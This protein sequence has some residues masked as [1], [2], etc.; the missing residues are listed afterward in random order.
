LLLEQGA[1]TE[2]SDYHARTCLMLACMTNHYKCAICKRT[3]FRSTQNTISWISI[4]S[5]EKRSR[6]KCFMAWSKYNRATGNRLSKVWH[7]QN[8]WPFMTF[9]SQREHIIGLERVLVL[10]ISQGG[11]HRPDGLRTIEEFVD[12]MEK[13]DRLLWFHRRNVLNAIRKGI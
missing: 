8:L 11:G 5:C 1:N 12:T 2:L 10:M 7:E 6:R 9:L 13:S 3:I 4:A